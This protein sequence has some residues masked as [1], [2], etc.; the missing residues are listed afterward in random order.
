MKS[1]RSPSPDCEAISHL[2]LNIWRRFNKEAGPADRLQTREFRKAVGFV[3]KFLSKHDEKGSFLGKDYFQDSNLLGA[4]ILYPW[5]IHYQQA[6]SVLGEL[7]ATPKRVLDVCSGAAPIAF[8]ALRHGASEV[9]ALDRSTAALE[10]GAQACGRYGMPLTVRRWDCFKGPLPVEGQFDLITLGHCLEE[11][12]PPNISG[13]QQ[14]QYVFIKSLLD[15]L[16]PEG[17]LIL[18]EN[19]YLDANRRVLQLRDKLVS[20]GIAVQ[21]PC[22]WRGDCPSLK[23]PDSPCFA[24]RQ[25]EKPYLIKEFQR[26]LEINLSSLKMT[27][28]IFKAPSA[29]WPSLPGE[30]IYR[31]ISPP[32]KSYQGERFYLCGT[33]GKKSLGSRL[34]SQPKESIAFDYLQRGELISIENALEQPSSFDIIEGTKL[35]VVAACGKPIGEA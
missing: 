10:L 2:L 30:E 23:T 29:T 24:Q 17:H 22:V 8:A 32:I 31:V 20:G 6:L 3:K 27:Y 19:S 9:Y 26:A 7:P 35:S 16:T 34:N 33:K 5:L 28:I 14:T 25:M 18:I 15:R 1:K 13:W 11:L 4:Y 12:F 21:A